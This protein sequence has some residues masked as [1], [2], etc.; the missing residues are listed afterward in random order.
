M[1]ERKMN[2]RGQIT[3][4]ILYGLLIVFVGIITLIVIGFF[5]TNLYSALDKNITLGQVDLQYYN[6]ATIGK[7][8]T[9]VINNADFWGLALAFGMILGLFAGAY[10]TRNSSPKIGIIIDIFIIVIAFLV[11]LY[12]KTVYSLVVTT[13]N[14]AGESFAI[15]YLPGTNFFLLHLPIFITIIG[16]VMMIIFHS[17]IPP[18]PEEINSN[19][20]IVT[21]G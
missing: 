19:T 3:I 14:K 6:N 15:N 4:F 1:D 18:K 11:S 7:F 2:K 5:S 16:V 9:M 12:I 20:T 21:T 8:N 10:F 13:L 17:S